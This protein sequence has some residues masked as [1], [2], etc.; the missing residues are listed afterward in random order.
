[1][2]MEG[3]LLKMKT[4]DASPVRY[5]LKFG[6]E[7]ICV[8]NLIGKHIELQYLNKIHCVKCGRLTSKSFAQ[9]YCYPCF[10][11]SPETEDCLLRPELCLAHEGIARDMQYAE[12]HC[13][14]EHIVYLSYTS[15]V[16][17]GVTRH[18][19]I[20][21]RWIDQGATAAIV[22]A[23]TPNRYTAGLIEVELK[24][25]F[26]DKTYWR[27][28]LKNSDVPVDLAQEKTKALEFLNTN[29]KTYKSDDN[30]I[31]YIKYPHTN[32]TDKI[33][34]INLDKDNYFPGV[35]TGIK[36]QYIIFSN[37]KVINIRKYGGYRVSLKF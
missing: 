11:S 25:Y 4:I 5:F 21:T 28:M 7:E 1:M 22:L 9:G 29:L 35:V 19:Q 24:S 23:R 26:A 6:M 14:I 30:S 15:C 18:T 2:E 33:S 12:K 20:P 13:L 17:V 32:I 36:G 10:R 16:K 37:G 31:H 34:S 3:T 27:A 8:N